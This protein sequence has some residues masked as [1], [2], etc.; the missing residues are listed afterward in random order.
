MA[1]RTKPFARALAAI[2]EF[3]GHLFVVLVLLLGFW[4]IEFVMH[5][6]WGP[7]NALPG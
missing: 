6:L 1:P 4:F 7:T 5:L 3:S 2:I